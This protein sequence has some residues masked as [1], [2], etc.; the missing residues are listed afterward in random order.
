MVV[1]KSF[2]ILAVGM[3]SSSV[4]AECSF[5]YI[6]VFLEIHRYAGPFEDIIGTVEVYSS[7]FEDIIGTVEVYTCPFEDKIGTVEV[8]SGPF[9]D[10]IGAVDIIS[11]GPLLIERHVRGSVVL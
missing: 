11:S 5:R 8:Y 10:K 6:F 2:I 3:Y 4:S 7:P 1:L 9:E